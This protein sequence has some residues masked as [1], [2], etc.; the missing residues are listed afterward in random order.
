MKNKTELKKYI[1]ITL[2]TIIILTTILYAFHKYEINTYKKNYNK[3]LSQI[4]NSIKNEYPNISELELINIINTE[5]KIKKD[6][7]KDFGISENDW[8]ILENEKIEKTNNIIYI[9]ALISSFIILLTIFLTYL[10][11]KNKKLKEI[12]NLLKQINNKNYQLEIDSNT[13]DELSILKN[14]LYKTTILLNEQAENN[15]KD[16]INLKT[17]LEDISHQL[18]TP[19]TSIIITLDNIIDNPEMDQKTRNIFVHKIKR[20]ITNINFLII[21]LLKLSKLETNTIKFNSK[22]HNLSEIINE[23]I[24]NISTISDLKNIKIKITGDEKIQIKC[25]NKWQTEALTNIIKNGIEY[26]KENSELKIN[27]EQNK[28]YTKIIIKN[29]GNINKKDLPHIFKRFYKSENKLDNNFGIGLNLAK[30]IIEKDNGK[31]FAESKN[32]I[33][34]FIIK[35]YKI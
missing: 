23:T 17:S 4:L 5:T 26:G 29:E 9:S 1:K 35:Y 27:Y 3:K 28:I 34:T 12:T 16:K 25:D 24:K 32:E 15:L 30:T 18:K 7:L 10:N 31:I 13:E 14:E 2:L 8:I 6:F 19:L 22:N 21:S 11:S 20:E 33:T